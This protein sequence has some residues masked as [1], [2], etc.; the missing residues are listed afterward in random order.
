MSQFNPTP[1]QFA[2][3]ETARECLRA[4]TSMAIDAGAGTGKTRVLLYLMQ[5]IIPANNSVLSVMF[6]RA[7]KDEMAQKIKAAGL[8]AQAVTF[9]GLGYRA[10]LKHYGV[11]S[12]DREINL[13]DGKY[14]KL[15]Q[16]L[17]KRTLPENPNRSMEQFNDA[18]SMLV[19]L[20]N[21]FRV[22]TTRDHRTGALMLFTGGALETALI[23]HDPD[24]MDA[25]QDL[26]FRYALTLEIPEDEPFVHRLVPKLLAF[27]KLALEEPTTFKKQLLDMVQNDRP[28]WISQLDDQKRWMD[29]TDQV[30]WMVVEQWYCYGSMVVLVDEAQDTSPLDRALVDMHRW[31]KNGHKLGIVIMVGD[32]QQ[33]IYRFRGADGAGFYNSIKFWNIQKVMPLSMSFR[34]P[35][36]VA[37]LAAMHKPGYRAHESNIDGEIATINEDDLF[38]HRSPARLLDRK[39]ESN[40]SAQRRGAD[41][42]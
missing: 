5:E 33:A 32:A 18:V 15:A 34:V 31:T 30:Y 37:A 28:Q 23:P 14:R 7:I 40:G 2:I 21:F 25:M 9:N 35:K 3:G 11:K 42:A 24:N 1:E 39:T 12:S 20:F 38:L 27:G 41:G 16:A 17:L 10:C 22:N 6:N 26:A 8:K 36:R 19:S 13:D 4:K 29:F